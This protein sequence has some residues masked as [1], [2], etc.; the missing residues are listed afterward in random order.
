MGEQA[1]D[2]SLRSAHL[3]RPGSRTRREGCSLQREAATGETAV[4]GPA[5]CWAGWT[6]P[7]SHTD[8][9][10]RAGPSGGGE[11]MFSWEK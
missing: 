4:P 6:A 11:L 2:R 8:P 3:G 1:A 7:G 9:Q 10:L 5:S